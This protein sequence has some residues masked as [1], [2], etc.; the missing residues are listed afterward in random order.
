M[1]SGH[2]LATKKNLA[3][4]TSFK[5]EILL[6][7]VPALGR[8]KQDHKFKISPTYIARPCLKNRKINLD[9]MKV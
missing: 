6:L 5:I 3:N 9:E 8:L 4:N 1:K 2:K 7:V